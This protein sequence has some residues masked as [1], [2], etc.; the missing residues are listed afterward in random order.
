VDHFLE[1]AA[2]SLK[3]RKPT[4]PPELLDLLGAYHFP[5]NIR[6]LEAMVFDAVS[7]HGARMLPMDVFKQY[8]NTIPSLPDKSTA[9]RFSERKPT[10][11]F[12]EKLPSIKET[13]RLLVS[14]SLNRANGNINIAAR[15]LGISHQALRKRLKKSNL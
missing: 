5:G 1:K 15:L 3:K 9:K 7:Q 14:E 4:P 10:I 6:E 12:S 8:I 13:T 11:M 2:L